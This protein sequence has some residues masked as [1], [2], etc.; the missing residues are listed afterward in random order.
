M[1]VALAGVRSTDRVP[2]VAFVGNALCFPRD[3]LRLVSLDLPGFQVRRCQSLDEVPRLDALDRRAIAALVLEEGYADRLA[4]DRERI[5][6]VAPHAH[7]ALA[8]RDQDL[9]VRLLRSLSRRPQLGGLSLLPM[10]MQYDAWRSV[11]LLLIHGEAYLPR[12]VVAA[13]LL[14][15]ARGG[16]DRPA[17][18]AAPNDPAMGLTGREVE[19][20]RLVSQGKQNKSV[21]AE[22]GLSEHTVKLHV[23][24]IITKLGARNRTEATIW[25]LSRL[26]AAGAER[27]ATADLGRPM[28]PN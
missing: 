20:L 12:D 17:P 8:Y 1:S 16:L 6:Q 24:H 18:R 9:A 11:L 27:L 4:E 2:V 28:R 3:L 23:H 13:A 15:M 26:G 14:P 19:V 22:L 25:Y 10:R 21:A 5:Q 7:L